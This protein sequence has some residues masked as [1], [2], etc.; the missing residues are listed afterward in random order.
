[1]SAAV[2]QF[3]RPPAPS[4]EARLWAEDMRLVDVLKMY[5]DALEGIVKFGPV[6]PVDR[7][8]LHAFH[9]ILSDGEVDP[10]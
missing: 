9:G 8:I 10:A 2:I 1:M 4:A 5:V 6:A 7:R 3:P